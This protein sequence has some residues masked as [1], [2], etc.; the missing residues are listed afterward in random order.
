MDANETSKLTPAQLTLL[1]TLALPLVAVP[2]LYIFREVLI[3]FPDVT[4]NHPAEASESAFE[5]SVG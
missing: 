4:C 2:A 3:S 1:F 5:K